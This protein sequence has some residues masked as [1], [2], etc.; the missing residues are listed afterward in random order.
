MKR[1]FALMLA[2]GL[3]CGGSAWASQSDD[4]DAELRREMEAARKELAEA[5]RKVA[6]LSRELG[7]GFAWQ[8]RT[9]DMPG[10]RA[11]LGITIDKAEDGGVQVLSVT[12]GGPADKAGLQAGDRITR[13]GKR[14]LGKDRPE[15]E[16]VSA[17]REVEP[18]QKVEIEYFRGKDRRKVEIEAE[19]M[20]PFFF[21]SFDELL[22]RA[23]RA[24]MPLLMHG[25]ADLELVSLTEGLGEYFG[26]KEGLLVVRAPKSDG[27]P[28]QDGD[29]I[30]SI[31]GR[32]PN[33]VHHAIRIL[34]SY[35]PGDTVK[36]DIV[37]KQKK[38]TVEA[39]I[40][41]RRLGMLHRADDNAR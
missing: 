19:A 10:R 16:L 32:K 35:N 4:R 9:E 8:F 37:R 20:R 27:I 30:L 15:R 18:G 11:M 31:D 7:E 39:V 6:E 12:P 36:I 28:L 13:I 22:P 21:G 24:P 3:A 34:R 29:V 26:T 5:A 25:W 23:P 14:D 40:P 17:M 2:A 1:L 38:T 33:D 41:D